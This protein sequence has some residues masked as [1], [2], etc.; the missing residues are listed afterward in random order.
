MPTLAL[1]FTLH[2][3][4]SS[5]ACCI[6]IT[7]S[8][9]TPHVQTHFTY[10]HFLSPL[11]NMAFCIRCNI[12]EPDVSELRV[13]SLTASGFALEYS[14]SSTMALSLCSSLQCYPPYIFH[15][16]AAALLFYSYATV[17]TIKHTIADDDLFTP[18]LISLPITTHHHE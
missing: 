13:R 15:H 2:C 14:M 7:G 12:A 17:G 5:F 16:A 18:P 9:Q 3:C 4:C 6:T 1:V 8:L 11:M 10:R